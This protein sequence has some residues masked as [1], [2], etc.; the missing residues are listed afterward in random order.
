MNCDWFKLALLLPTPTSWFSL[1]RK[2]RSQ[3]RKHSDSFSF[4]VDSV[5]LMTPLTTP[6]FD[7]HLVISALTSPLTTP[8][9]VKTNF[10]KVG[11]DEKV[12]DSRSG[13]TDLAPLGPYFLTS[14]QIFSPPALPLS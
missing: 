10:N 11:P 13:R 12:F 8:L 6:I 2:R 1:D 3:K 9:L 4:D 5:A 14:N 7:Y